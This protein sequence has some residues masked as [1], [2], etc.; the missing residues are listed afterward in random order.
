M[1]VASS[2]DPVVARVVTRDRATRGRTRRIA[3]TEIVKALGS[4]LAVRYKTGTPGR[5]GEAA[6]ARSGVGGRQPGRN[7]DPC[8]ARREFFPDH[9]IIGEEIDERP[10]RDHDFVWAVDPIDGTANFVNGFPM[11]A[12][13]L[14][15]LYRGPPGGRRAVVLDLACAAAGASITPP[16]GGKLRFDGA[17]VTPKVNPSVRRKLAGV[18]VATGE[19]GFWDTRKTGSAAIECAMVAAGLL[20]VARFATPNIWDVAGGIALVEAAGGVIRQSTD[21]KGWLPMQSFEP[22]RSAAGV[23]DLRYW[24]RAIIVGTPDAAQQMCAS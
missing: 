21:G 24:R 4:L 6:L 23:A 8:P 10:A 18:P 20:Q 15:V 14:G 7:A 3:G 22:G 13:S 17:D 2:A 9:D 1:N 16:A 11:F 12:A 5:R 19:E